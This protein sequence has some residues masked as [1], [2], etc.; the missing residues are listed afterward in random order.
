M[1]EGTNICKQCG[2]P[3]EKKTKFCQYCGWKNKKPFYKKWWFWVIVAFVLIGV[4][5]NSGDDSG[6]SQAITTVT[7]TTTAKTTT[8]KATTT[9]TTAATTAAVS[10]PQT[11]LFESDGI[12]I[13]AK[14]LETKEGRNPKLH[15]LIENNSGEDL[16]FQT[17]DT[18]INGCMVDAMFSADV[19]DGKKVNDAITLYESDMSLYGIEEISD[20][21]FYFHIFLSET[22][23]DFL[24]TPIVKVQT[25]ANPTAKH[26]FNSSGLVAYDADGVKITVLGVE[27]DVTLGSALMVL[28]ENNTDHNITVQSRNESVNGYMMDTIFSPEIAAG[29]YM[30]DDLTFLSS[31]LKENEIESIEEVELYFVVFDSNKWS[32]SFE[33]ETIKY[34]N[35]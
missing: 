23:K 29:K 15:V 24:D 27:K 18:S 16:T 35:E 1:Q 25:D 32:N 22:W 19:A 31:S 5:G 7:A 2:K 14:S 34:V 4:I 30:I 12:K 8:A 33:T 26:S 17:R 6:E 20:I 21:E 11:V 9:A 13:T 28:I 10:I 3:I